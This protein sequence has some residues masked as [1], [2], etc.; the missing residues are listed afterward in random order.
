MSPPN[1]KEWPQRDVDLL[2]EIQGVAMEMERHRG[3]IM[4]HVAKECGK[5]QADIAGLKAQSRMWGAAAGIGGG[6]VV[7]LIQVLLGG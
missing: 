7:V 1:G 2:K 6:A 4:E 5:L 3:K